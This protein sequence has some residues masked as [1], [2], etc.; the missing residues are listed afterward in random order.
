MYVDTL[1]VTEIIFSLQQSLLLFHETDVHDF[2]SFDF[3]PFRWQC[4]NHWDTF[5]LSHAI[6]ISMDEYNFFHQVF[7]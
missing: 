7:S 5:N 1:H 6:S 2:K 4:L 3:V